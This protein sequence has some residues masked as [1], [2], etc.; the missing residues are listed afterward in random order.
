MTIV[1]IARRHFLKLAGAAVAVPGTARA[2]DALED[3]L[4]EQMKTRS[5]P[6]LAIAV[7]VAGGMVQARALGYADLARRKRVTSR[8]VFQLASVTKQ[9]VASAVMLLVQ[10]RKVSI[11]APIT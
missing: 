6:G 4:S 2:G 11:D 5:L 3:L 7:M 10:D 8:T 1:K 9:F